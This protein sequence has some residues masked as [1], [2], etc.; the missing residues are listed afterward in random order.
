M[1]YDQ[2]RI[3]IVGINIFCT[4][5]HRRGQKG[6]ARIQGVFGGHFQTVAAGAYIQ[7]RE[8]AH[9]A[10]T[11]RNIQVPQT[12]IAI[13]AKDLFAVL[14][15]GFRDAC[16]NGSFACSALAGQNRDQLSHVCPSLSFVMIIIKR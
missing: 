10:H 2:K 7:K 8:G 6:D 15:Q 16:A 13:D 11:K 4:H 12:H 14:R 1:V 9:L 5:A 3:K